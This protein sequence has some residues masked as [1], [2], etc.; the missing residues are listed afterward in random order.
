MTANAECGQERD[1]TGLY[2][3]DYDLSTPESNAH[4]A[5]GSW[6]LAFRILDHLRELGLLHDADCVLDPMAGTSRFPIAACAQ[7]LRAIGVELEPRF[8]AFSEQNKE[9]AARKLGCPL[10][11]TIIQ[12]DARKLSELL[13]ER[14]LVTVTSPPYSEMLQGS[15][16]E[17]AR[18][19]IAEGRYHGKRPDVWTSPGNR[20][21]STYGD[22]YGSTPGQIGALPDKPL[23]TVTSPP[24][25][26]SDSR[27]PS[28]G[29]DS[30]EWRKK[31]K[32]AGLVRPSNYEAEGQIGQEQGPNYLSEMKKVYAQI[33][34]V[35][36]VLVIVVKCPTRQGK[37]RRL[38]LDSI[39]LLKETGWRIHCVH[40]AIL[41]EEQ[42]TQ[43]LFGEPKK[44]VKGRLSFFKLL[45]YRKGSPVANHEDVIFAVRDGGQG[46]L[47]AVMSPPYQTGT[48]EGHSLDALPTGKGT[49][50]GR[51]FTSKG[52]TYAVDLGNTPGQ[53]G[54]LRG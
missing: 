31:R 4:P 3:R 27:G 11:M 54:N 46:N 53:I 37:L 10:D 15:G 34:L 32:S 43:T 48:G 6:D 44:R 12:G 21:G 24:Y 45:S 36:D 26:D 20:A 42:E 29:I 18:Q 2:R 49:T 5:K 19:R 8:V 13:K 38:D 7:G 35:S 30:P 22:G 33:A 41:F 50:R 23:I 39:S 40:R 9:Y 47:K 17:A 52:P 25:E 14:G 28:D 16:A 1:W 51:G